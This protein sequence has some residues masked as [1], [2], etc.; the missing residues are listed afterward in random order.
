MVS[1]ILNRMHKV[2]FVLLLH[3]IRSVEIFSCVRAC[4]CV[5][6]YMHVRVRLV[7]CMCVPLSINY[8]QVY[9]CSSPCV[10]M[11]CIIFN[12]TTNKEI[13]RRIGIHTHIVRSR[14]SVDEDR[15]IA[16]AR[17]KIYA[18]RSYFF[19]SYTQRIHILCIHIFCD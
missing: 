14:H 18:V 6:A 7:C 1:F 3:S 2:L 5:R 19:C 16:L 12:G 15:E 8:F 4:K 11:T 10:N 13:F 9:F 17:E